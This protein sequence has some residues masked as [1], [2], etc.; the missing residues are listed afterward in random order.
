MRNLIN[1]RTLEQSDA[2]VYEDEEEEEEEKVVPDEQPQGTQPQRE[3]Q[4]TD[5]RFVLLDEQIQQLNEHID[6]QFNA[7]DAR[8]NGF[9]SYFNLINEAL[10]AILS[11]LG[12]Q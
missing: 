9:D 4:A 5:A 12:N 6:A 3:Q 11:R 10:T 2:H 8:L 7:V 1:K